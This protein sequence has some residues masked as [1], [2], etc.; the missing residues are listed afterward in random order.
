LFPAGLPPWKLPAG[1]SWLERGLRAEKRGRKVPPA[2]AAAGEKAAGLHSLSAHA[3]GGEAQA[4]PPSLS[5][6][7][8]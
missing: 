2:T 1:M 4:R 7:P 5:M 6:A 3:A 8:R